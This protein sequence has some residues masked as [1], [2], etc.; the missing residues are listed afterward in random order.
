MDVTRSVGKKVIGTVVGFAL[1]FATGT[2]AAQAQ[3]NEISIFG[4]WEDVDEPV[5]AEVLSLNLRYGRFM[6]PRVVAMGTLSRNSFDA[7]GV[8]STTTA[9][10][11]GAKY[12]FGELR[13][14]AI[15]PFAEASI[16]FANTDSGPNDNTDL[17]WEFGG[18]AAL[19]IDERTS[20]DGSLRFYNTDTD[21][22]TRGLRLFLGL[23]TRF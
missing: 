7:P 20:I 16:G 23:T 1:L 3:S 18:G 12:Y 14:Q 15:V 22:R 11:V 19:M 6:T 2:A 13:P 17:T 8:D 10:L 21:A 9:F 4:S 5:D